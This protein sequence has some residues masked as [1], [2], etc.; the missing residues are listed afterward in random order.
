M[1]CFFFAHYCTLK[2]YFVILKSGGPKDH[3]RKILG[4][5]KHRK[6]EISTCALIYRVSHWCWL[7][8]ILRGP[9]DGKT[10]CGNWANISGTLGMPVNC[11]IKG[12]LI[13]ESQT[14][15][16]QILT[17][18]WEFGTFVQPNYVFTSTLCYS[19]KKIRNVTKRSS[20]ILTLL[21]E[22]ETFVQTN[23]IFTST[24]CYSAKKIWNVTKRSS[25]ILTL[26]WEFGTFV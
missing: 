26:L 16:V 24:L 9:K 10:P 2:K 20:S 21:W 6:G 15:E 22:F 14:I 17:L 4:P 13:S 12:F 11:P 5:Y 25:S 8:F 7:N 1:A 3:P 18:L 19:A 23:Y